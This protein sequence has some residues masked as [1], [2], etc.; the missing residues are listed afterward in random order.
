[1][2]MMEFN[3]ALNLEKEFGKPIKPSELAKFL[4]VD[5][6]TVIKYA[7]RWGG[8]EVSPGRYRFFD[9]KVKEVLYAEFDK[10]TW[11][12]AM[13]RFRT[14]KS[15]DS[16]KTVS[17]RFEKVSKGGGRLG[18]RNQKGTDDGTVR[19]PFGFLDGN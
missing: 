8:V 5:C 6:R 10:E 17:G 15:L 16:S 4:G 14:G 9:K 12:K 18:K 2:P 13:A 11:Q 1:M 19:D 3:N 7:D